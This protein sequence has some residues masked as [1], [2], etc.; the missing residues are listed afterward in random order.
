MRQVTWKPE[1]WEPLNIRHSSEKEKRYPSTEE[2]KS[3]YDYQDLSEA[4]E[5]R[6]IL[7]QA[8]RIFK[9]QD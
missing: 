2:V 4:Y 1:L 9:D 8:P 7:P 3:F 6:G 5:V